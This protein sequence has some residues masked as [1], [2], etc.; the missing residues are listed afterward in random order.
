MIVLAVATEADINELESFEDRKEFL[1]DIG[2]NEP[3]SSVLIKKLG[4]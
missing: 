2:L 4:K 1:A 3:G